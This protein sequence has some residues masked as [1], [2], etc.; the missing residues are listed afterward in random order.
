MLERA[1]FVLAR[2]RGSHRIYL[3]GNVRI[4]VPFHP[5]R[6]LH[7]KIAKQVLDAIETSS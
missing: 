2:S 6:D 4:V 5:G 7:P 1:G 3:K